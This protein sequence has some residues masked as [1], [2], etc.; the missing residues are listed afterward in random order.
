[1]ARYSELATEL[2]DL[3][4]GP[5]V[6]ATSHQATAERLAATNPMRVQRA[7]HSD[8]NPLMQPVAALAEQVRAGRQAAPA[9]NP[10]RQLEQVGADLVT[11]W[12]DGVRDLQ[13]AMIESSFHLIWAAPP[14]TALGRWLR[15]W[16]RICPQRSQ[17][18]I[19]CAKSLEARRTRGCCGVVKPRG[20]AV[21]A[22]KALRPPF[23]FGL[24]FATPVGSP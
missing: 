12:W 5:V 16:V 4:L 13:Y 9:D 14:V 7:L 15:S 21:D 23:D 8:S 20:R 1:V 19:T 2:Y 3:T 17:C 24:S 18:P 10:F 6:R 22:E 11:Q